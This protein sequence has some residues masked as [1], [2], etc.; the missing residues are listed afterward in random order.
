MTLSQSS[1][2]WIK[3]IQPNL[4][5]LDDIPLTGAASF[6]WEEL[7]NRIARCFDR[8]NI[9]IKPGEITWRSKD[10]L[11]DGL[12]D[13]PFPLVFSVLPLKGQVCWV[14]PAQ[15]VNILAALLLTK[16]THPLNL[17]DTDLI[18]S[19]YRFL[20]LEVL[21]NFTQVAFDKTL[22]P[23]LTHQ[24]ALPQQDSLCLDVSLLL[25]NQTIWGR[26][27]ISPEFRQSWVEHFA[28]QEA[29]FSPEMAK[30]IHVVVHVE[31]GKAHLSL[32]EWMS[33]KLGDVVLLDHCSLDSERLDGRV[34]LTVNGK[35]TFRA[36]FKNNG[37]LKIL[38]LPLL[39]EV[40]SPM[41]KYSEDDD[42]DELND[43][44]DL[45]ESDENDLLEDEEE[46]FF[47]DEDDFLTE[48]EEETETEE[49]TTSDET[50]SME[51]EEES[52]SASK[53][54]KATAIAPDQIPVNLIVEVGQIQMTMDQLL[55]LEPGNLLEINIHPKNGVD[56][57]I[58]GKIVGKGELIRIGE[59][60]G[61]RV[62]QLGH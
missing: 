3:E 25:Q 42:S 22:S 6:P 24:T 8:E 23:I 17:H 9:A 51:E 44:D 2:D 46:E 38:E 26:L 18:E 62:L 49:E 4:K 10:K 60:L 11:Y 58:N 5:Q 48:D 30:L 1:Y 50:T 56:L 29:S 13:D 37:T 12:G 36:K 55:K 15:E 34:M 47:E 16:E 43:M 14:M 27:V 59:V 20:A 19:F 53:E 21:Y 40:D 33:V 28:Q 41:G 61:V 54:T 57:T 35:Q 32:A 52:L 45:S 39:H 7:S 31:A